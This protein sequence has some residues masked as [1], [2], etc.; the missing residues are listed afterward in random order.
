MPTR[1]D[2]WQP[3][4]ALLNS[5]I[6]KCIAESRRR[7]SDGG[8]GG[9]VVAGGLV[10]AALSMIVTAGTGNPVFAFGILVALA[11]V[12]LAYTGV[13]APPLLTDRTKVLAVAGG[14]G[15][16]PAGYL[17]YPPAWEAGMPEYL[18]GA[19]TTERRLRIAVKLCREHPGAVADLLRLVHK[20]ENF[21]V[22]HRPGRDFSEEGRER[23]VLKTATKLVEEL[24][25]MSS[26][27]VLVS[28]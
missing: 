27:R 7:A 1:D 21:V 22:V 28:N 17:V 8:H 25:G 2:R 5:V 3:T 18:A 6:D 15:H 11:V 24:S 14:P 10:L 26:T 19:G 9:A 12:G 16:L 23:E 13:K 20:A 4:D